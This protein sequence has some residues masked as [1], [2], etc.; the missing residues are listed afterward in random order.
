[1]TNPP[2]QVPICRR[3]PENRPQHG[4]GPYCQQCNRDIDKDNREQ[5]RQ[6]RE[7]ELS[8]LRNRVRSSTETQYRNAAARDRGRDE[9]MRSRDNG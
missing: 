8:E 5:R 4:R 7:R 3:C 6:A 2:T 1:M 9:G